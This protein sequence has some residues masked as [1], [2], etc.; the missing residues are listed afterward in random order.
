MSEPVIHLPLNLPEFEVIEQETDQKK[1]VIIVRVKSRHAWARCPSCGYKRREDVNDDYWRKAQDLPAMDYK[2][3]LKIRQRRM[4]CN[5]CKGR[6]YET[7]ESLDAK[8]RQTKRLQAHLLSL[9]RGRSL[10]E[11]A[12]DSGVAYRVLHYLYFRLGQHHLDHVRP[13]PRRIGVD[14]FAI[15]KGHNY[16]TSI[17]GL[18]FSFVWG[19]TKDRTKEA[20]EGLL[21]TPGACAWRVKESVIDMWEPFFLALK[22]T[23]RSALI[24]IDRYHVE[25]HLYEAVDGCRKRISKGLKNCPLKEARKLFLVPVGKLSP[26]QKEKRN[27]L[28]KAYPQLAKAVHLADRLHR[29]YSVPKTKGQANNQ[30]GYW[31]RCLISSEIPEPVEFAK[32]VKRWRRYIVN[33]FVSRSTNGISEG[34]NTKF[35]LIKRLGYGRLTFDHLTARIFLECAHSP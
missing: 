6:F 12:N 14:E 15:R 4:Y 25:R 9:A 17:V 29:W 3:V 13:L 8:Q 20:L 11:A 35:K 28:L 18:T 30:L 31:L 2:V 10:L 34:F 33:F 23:L 5:R 21:R 7:F 26:Q 32:M 27:D 22:A 24:V 16:A 1:D 19:I